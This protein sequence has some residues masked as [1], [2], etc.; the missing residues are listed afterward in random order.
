M[1]RQN[2]RIAIFHSNRLFREGLSCCL[3][4]V[5]SIT[6]VHSGASLEGAPEILVSYNPDLL[7][8]QFDLFHREG[9]DG[10]AGLRALSSEFKTMVIEV[11]DNEEDILSCVE[12][13]GASGYLLVD[14]SIRD[15]TDNIMAIMR[16][17]TL[18]SPRVAS[19]AFCRMS[20]LARQISES[21]SVN[22]GCLTKR[23][24]EIIA[25]IE[26]GLSNK[27]IA[28]RLHVEVS[29]VKNHVHNVL[30]KL[31]LHDRRSAVQCLK[32]QKLIAT[33]F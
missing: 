8:L 13:G 9:F 15:L 31:Q 6:V 12:V 18:C 14:A 11:P 24:T 17:E 19:L 1:E 28:V 26:G 29:T 25:L 21:R 22:M 7:I 3:T 23:E 10:Y 27:E 2:I 4:Q 5:E 33:R 16:G 20:R 30:D 32:E